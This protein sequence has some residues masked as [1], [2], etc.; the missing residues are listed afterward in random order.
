MNLANLYIP[1]K[2]VDTRSFFI[3]EQN[4]VVYWSY[5]VGSGIF[6]S[7]KAFLRLMHDSHFPQ[8]FL[9]LR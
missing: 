5:L 1:L 9:P 8:C 7:L 4:L 2:I 3:E 6:A